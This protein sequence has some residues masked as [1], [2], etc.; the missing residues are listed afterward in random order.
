MGKEKDKLKASTK[1]KPQHTLKEKRQA[2]RDK[3]E[4]KPL[5][6]ISH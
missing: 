2:K 3:A 4:G 5:P 1:K 6:L